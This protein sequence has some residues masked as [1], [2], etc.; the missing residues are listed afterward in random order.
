MAAKKRYHDSLHHGEGW[1]D[2]RYSKTSFDFVNQIDPF[3][4]TNFI[5]TH[6]SVMAQ[7]IANRPVKYDFSKSKH[8]ITSKDRKNR[9]TDVFARLTGIRL[10]EYRNYRLL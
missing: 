9:I 1:Q 2:E 6:P 8:H 5:G 10:G 3:V 4:L 7:R